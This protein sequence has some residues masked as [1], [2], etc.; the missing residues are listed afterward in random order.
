MD[1]T[2][3]LPHTAV[4]GTVSYLALCLVHSKQGQPPVVRNNKGRAL[5]QAQDPGPLHRV[6]PE[7]ARVSRKLRE[8]DHRWAPVWASP[9]CCLAGGSVSLPTIRLALPTAWPRP[10]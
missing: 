8:R 7:D 4:T 1:S 6:G 9:K 2:Q 10:G 5:S 3:H